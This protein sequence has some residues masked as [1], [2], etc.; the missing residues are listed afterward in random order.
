MHGPT[1]C[2]G[3]QVRAKERAAARRNGPLTRRPQR[4]PRSS[5]VALNGQRQSERGHQSARTRGG[6]RVPKP[7]ST[8]TPPCGIARLKSLLD[9]L[10]RTGLPSALTPRR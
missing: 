8:P 5:T 10:A 3:V 2:S 7:Q 9:Q 1:G 6:W 4:H